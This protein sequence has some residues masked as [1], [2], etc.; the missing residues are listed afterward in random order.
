MG[1]NYYNINDRQSSYSV[2]T[3]SVRICKEV[4]TEMK[5]MFAGKYLHLSSHF[6]DSRMEPNRITQTVYASRERQVYYTCSM[7]DK[8]DLYQSPRNSFRIRFITADG[9]PKCV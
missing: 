8:T 9:T 3:S 1:N 7:L 5:K 6:V 2:C 4:A